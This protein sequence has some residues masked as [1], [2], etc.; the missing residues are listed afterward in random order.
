MPDQFGLLKNPYSLVIYLNY[1]A[2][3]NTND[4][5]CSII[6]KSIL[7]KEEAFSKCEYKKNIAK[8]K[9]QRQLKI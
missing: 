5:I 6:T 3:V 7:K 8:T 1:R 9:N 2:L 4:R